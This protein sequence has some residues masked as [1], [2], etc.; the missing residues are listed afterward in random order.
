MVAVYNDA[1][2]REKKLCE[3]VADTECS[4]IKQAAATLIQR[5][6]DILAALE[7]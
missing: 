1:D 6:S 5:R 4:T 7:E 2:G 3:K